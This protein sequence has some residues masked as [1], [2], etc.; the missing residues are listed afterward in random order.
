MGN[1]A[2]SASPAFVYAA[3][4]FQ[5]VI[6]ASKEFEFLLETE[7]QAEGK[8][9]HEKI[10]SASPP[11]PP[12]TVKSLRYIA[13]VRNAVVHDRSVKALPNRVVFISKCKSAMEEIQI[14]ID[15][16]RMDAETAARGPVRPTDA[17]SLM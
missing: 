2:S 12:P 13:S 10:S 6:E 14:I 9:L 7:F 17:C 1:V 8:G 4:D 5:L 3:N 16:K 11:L 15:K